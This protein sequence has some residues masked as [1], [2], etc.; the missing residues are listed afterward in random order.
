M[1]LPGKATAIEGTNTYF[2]ASGAKWGMNCCPDCG[3][4]VIAAYTGCPPSSSPVKM[5]G[6]FLH[7]W[8]T[9]LWQADRKYEGWMG[10]RLLPGA[11]SHPIRAHGW[12]SELPS[13]K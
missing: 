8:R 11:A 4:A 6:L 1:R 13:D 9:H 7:F 3:N 5:Q 2:L 10:F 12:S